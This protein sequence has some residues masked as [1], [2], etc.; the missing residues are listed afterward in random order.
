M[1]NLI[2][3]IL[4]PFIIVMGVVTLSSC[5]KY[6]ERTQLADIRETDPYKNFRN[7]QGFVEEMYNC[8]PLYSSNNFHNSFNLGEEEHW[9]A[10]NNYTRGLLYQVDQGNYMA[11][12]S[13]EYGFLGDGGDPVDGTNHTTK[14][15][16]WGLSWYAIRKANVGLANLDKLVEATQEEKNL[17]A[18]QLYFFR[19]FYHFMLM[20]YWG[21]LPY[22]DQA[23]PVDEV[24]KLKRLSYQAC[25][26]KVAEDMQKA[27]DLLPVDWDKIPSGAATSGL[28]NQ[29]INKIMAMCFLGKNYLYAGSPL[30]NLEST[31]NS[32]YNTDFCKKASDVF[33]QA[34]QLIESTGRYQL[35]PFADYR[36]LI[37]TYNKGGQLPG[38]KEAILL[39]NLSGATNR[40]RW[41]QVNDYRP[42]TI[43]PS[44]I[45][46]YPT[47]NYADYYGMANGLPIP[48]PEKPDSES[49][50][51]PEYPWRN[52][53]PRFYNDY[54]IDG[55]KCVLNASSVGN[56]L[57][58]QYA[59][60]YTG[61]TYRTVDGNSKVWTGYMNS[62]LVSK[63]V[64]DKDGYRDNNTLVLSLMRLAD[65]YLLYAEATATGYGSP[66]SVG[67]GYTLS[68]VDA[69]NKVRAR[70][71]V[72]G[73]AAKFLGSTAS[74]LG[75]VRR[76]RAVELSFEGHRFNDLRRWL[77]LTERPYTLRKAIEFD[78]D[79]P[80]A[81]IYADPKNAKVKNF[82][83]TVLFERQLGQRHYWFPFLLKDVSIYS[84]F[85]QNPGW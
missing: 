65:V 21:G 29:R 7:F 52:R 8:I 6:L 33:A 32:G 13:T 20:Q 2:K 14:G 41:N 5:K 66:Q 73:V 38:G 69:V 31:G 25:A 12:N 45:K 76:E 18:G 28:N 49:G 80:N 16:L 62:K 3:N 72:N 78:R 34:L 23:L 43:H 77:L 51:N 75:E 61:G 42:Q 36:E 9:E 74:F 27:V 70:A 24:L 57:L 50:Y 17:I 1:R 39:E 83:E 47:A 55:E 71:G 22:I 46:M 4:F 44:G 11:W 53:D 58:R 26:N 60:L 54:V 85:K 81:Q 68:A 67:A 84:E 15:R 30:M 56:D 48:D 35:V 79:T 59:S 37:Y 19:G 10:G 64:N 82:R 40:W 63:L